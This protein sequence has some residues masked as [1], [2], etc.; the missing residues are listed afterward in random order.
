M[1]T[2]SPLWRPRKF[3]LL[4]PFQRP[5]IS[6]VRPFRGSSTPI[7]TLASLPHVSHTVAILS[8]QSWCEQCFFSHER[9]NVRHPA[10]HKKLSAPHPLQFRKVFT[11]APPRF[12]FNSSRF[13]IQHMNRIIRTPFSNQA[14]TRIE[15]E[16]RQQT[17]KTD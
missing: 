6:T 7:P 14:L 17:T 8:P 2:L 10:N 3:Y 1:L 16:D 15:E 12:T 4:R 5:A 9:E 13:S 11:P